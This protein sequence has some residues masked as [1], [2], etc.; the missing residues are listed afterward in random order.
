MS[1]RRTVALAV[2]IVAL[3]FGAAITSFVASTLLP[4]IAADLDARNRLGLLIAGSTL[5]LFV[6]LPLATRVIRRIGASAGLTLGAAGYLGGLAVAASS[7]T[8]WT[9]AAGQFSAGLS[10]G[11]LGVFGIGAAIE[12]LEDRVR[13]RVVAASAAMWILPALVGP[14]ATLGLEHLVGWRWTLVAPVPIVLI[15]RVLVVRVVRRSAATTATSARPLGPTLLVPLGAALV[16]FGFGGWP[17][18]ALGCLLALAGTVAIMPRGTAAL[19]RG[20]PAAL[21]AMVLFAFG[22]FGADSLVTVLLTDGYAAGLGHAAIVLSAA[23]L[24][25]GVTSLC[26]TALRRRWNGRRFPVVGLSL[27]SA[28]TAG[29]TALLVT[30]P[31]V[32]IAVASWAVAGMGV[33]LAYPSLYLMAS[34]AG[35]SGFTAT[36]LATAVITAEAIGGLLGRATGGALTS[37]ASTGG[38]TATYL[39]YSIALATAALVAVRAPQRT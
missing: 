17:V 1:P 36:E 6:A 5:G 21:A 30:T 8:A 32:P 39:T 23:P 2:G 16:V 9:F 14:A 27:A 34:T 10:S 3:E 20:T 35:S 29:L 24:A 7:T 37:T 13:E 18:A 4:V 12:H 19:R 28:G 38:L 11:L 33:G 26:A 31:S 22:Y 25:W 15:G